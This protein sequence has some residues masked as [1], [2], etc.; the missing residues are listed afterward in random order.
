LIR[1]IRASEGRIAAIP[2]AAVTA[3]ARDDERQQAL[4]AG[5][6]LHVAKPVEPDQLARTVETLA[7]GSSIV[8]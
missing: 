5:F 6:H 8:H 4:A 2:A 7:R 3:H 1:R